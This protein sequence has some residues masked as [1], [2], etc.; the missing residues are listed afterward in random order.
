VAAGATLA[1]LLRA[2]QVAE[3]EIGDVVARAASVFD[4]RRLR[5]AQPY[6][7]EQSI[8]GTVRC[9]EYEIDGD[10]YLRLTRDR[11][12]ILPIAK[13]RELE[14][15]RG[16]IDRRTS[17]LF[18]AMET[19]GETVDLSLSLAAIFSGEIDFNVDL[20]PGDRFELVVEKQYREQHAFAGYGPIVAAEFDNAG[21][22]LR[23]VRFTPRGGAPGYFDERGVS[24]RRFMLKSPLKFQPIVT[25]RFSRARLHPILRE[26]RPHLGV[27]YKAPA[28]APVVASADGVVVEAGMNGGAGRMVHLRH[29]NGFESEYLH[30]SSIAVRPGARV[31]QGDL[32]GRVGASGLATGPHLDY[33]VKR[34]GAFVNPLTVH[35][36][37]PPADPVP[38]AEL[39]AFA[40]ARDRALASLSAPAVAHASDPDR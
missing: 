32:I 24:L 27:D 16:A 7:L 10:R 11:V 9:F 12:E 5:T 23:A 30:L 15:V 3:R 28:G 14:I 21:R 6:R 20:Q 34:N 1:S 8:D 19:A 35:R 38:A 2:N 18:A 37:L 13:T 26:V 39:A 25:S 33:R 4:V 17:S 36:L 40:S 22:R 29:P 31:R